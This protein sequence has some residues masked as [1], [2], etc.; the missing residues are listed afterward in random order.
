MIK[1]ITKIKNSEGSLTKDNPKSVLIKYSERI[2]ET[3]LFEDVSDMIEIIPLL[4]NV[5]GMNF[6]YVLDDEDSYFRLSIAKT[7]V[8]LKQIIIPLT[9]ERESFKNDLRT[10]KNYGSLVINTDKSAY[11]IRLSDSDIDYKSFTRKIRNDL[12]GMGI[13]SKKQYSFMHQLFSL[14]ASEGLFCFNIYTQ[15]GLSTDLKYFIY[16]DS[17]I[18]VQIPD[19]KSDDEQKKLCCDVFLR[20]MKCAE[21]SKMILLSLVAHIGWCFEFL[22][23]LSPSSMRNLLPTTLPLIY[24]GSGTGKTTL[25]KAIFDSDY[26]NRFI[27]LS[28]STKSGVM[29]KMCSIYGGTVIL[30]DIPHI[31]L[32]K[33]SKAVLDCFEMILRTYGDIGAEKQTAFKQNQRVRAWAAVT[34]E[35]PFLNIQS[36][37]LRVFPIEIIR[38][39]IHFDELEKLV[40]MRSDYDKYIVSFLNWL[41]QHITIGTDGFIKIPLLEKKY[42]EVR[43]E[44]YSKYKNIKEARLI[45][46]RIQFESYWNFFCVFYESI[47]IN[48][49]A[50]E[51]YSQLLNKFLIDTANI[52]S[53]WVHDS[54]LE[55]CIIRALSDLL[56]SIHIYQYNTNSDIINN[57]DTSS[58]TAFRNNNYLVFTSGQRQ[59]F[60]RLI[61]EKAGTSDITDRIIVNTM[62]SMG[63]VCVPSTGEQVKSK[64]FDNR[65][66]ENGRS[67]RVLK[68][69]IKNLEV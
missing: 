35:A 54:T 11:V 41:C 29:K 53:D 8:N 32:G 18:N 21:P 1:I 66:T 2:K 27:A 69:Y 14:I 42:A 43:A 12:C 65:I 59:N 16:K 24:G 51:Q 63:I 3:T 58:I 68:I 19:D 44:A 60:F 40:E 13:M 7:F 34:A 62:I 22:Q 38:G 17:E 45:D 64:S 20:I 57:A 46:T 33:C 49:G 52:Q 67:K 37:L 50:L 5:F 15:Q 56:E 31:S 10:R 47:G 61:R 23:S 6:D 4:V 36:S 55:S 48:P 9:E 25:V 28:N 26:Q 39:D 30:D